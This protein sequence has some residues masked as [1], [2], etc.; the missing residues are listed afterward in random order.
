MQVDR[1]YLVQRDGR[2][3]CC[4]DQQQEE[5]RRPHHAQRHAVKDTRQGDE[6]ERRPRRRLDA[7]AEYRREDHH[8]GQYGH[9]CVEDGDVERRVAQVRVRF[10]IRGVGHHR[11]EYKFGLYKE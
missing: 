3:E 10:E 1:D 4:D 11:A 9:Q 8:A 7:Y 5:N 2:G 6:Y